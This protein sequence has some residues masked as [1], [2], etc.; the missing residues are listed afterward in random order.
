MTGKIERGT[1]EAAPKKTP[2]A[3]DK[4]FAEQK[5]GVMGIRKPGSDSETVPETQSKKAKPR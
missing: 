3:Q 5:Q 4:A 2:Q 1:H